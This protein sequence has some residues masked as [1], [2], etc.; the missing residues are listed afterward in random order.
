MTSLFFKCVIYFFLI[1]WQLFLWINFWKKLNFLLITNN[2]IFKS[3][4]WCIMMALCDTEYKMVG[5]NPLLL[6][7]GQPQAWGWLRTIDYDYDYSMIF[8]SDYDYDY[9]LD[10]MITIMILIIGIWLRLQSWLHIY[11]F[12]NVK[13]LCE[14]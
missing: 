12:S 2:T 14:F 9:L 13:N 7:S 3:G 8:F 1:S 4:L 5:W 6:N 11:N 10:I